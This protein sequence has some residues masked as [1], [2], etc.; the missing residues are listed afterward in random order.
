MRWV[1]VPRD[2]GK[3][4]P[5]LVQGAYSFLLRN[6][7]EAIEYFRLPPDRVVEIGREFAI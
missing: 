4:L 7:S 3:G 5:G 6:S 2:D 1:V